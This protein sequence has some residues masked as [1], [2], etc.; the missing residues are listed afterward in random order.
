MK[1]NLLIEILCEELP[2]IPFL[3]EEKHILKKWE[4]ILDEYH[5]SAKFDFFYTP[6][7]LVLVSED[8]PE[9]QEDQE[10]EFFG[11][12][13]AIAYIDGDKTKG[14][15]KAGES[16]LKKCHAQSVE[17]IQKD[18][19]K[20]LY[21][22]QTLQGKSVQDLLGE[23]ILKWL[24]SLQFG[25]SMRWGNLESSFIRPIRSVVALF[26]QKP[27]EFELF[28]V[29][30]GSHTFIH[31]DYGFDPRSFESLDEYFKILQEGGVILD[32]QKRREKILQEMREIEIQ[33]DVEIELDEELLCEVVA[34]TESPRAVYG[35]FDREFLELPQEVII[36][37]MKENQRYFALYQNG[38]LHHGFIVVIN[39]MSDDTGLIIEGNQKV[40]RARLSD[41]MFF[42]HNDLKRPLASYDLSKVT[43][44]EGLG[45]M[46]DK[47]EREKAIAAFLSKNNAE[48]LEAVTISKSDLLSE[49]V[50]EFPELQGVMGEYYA[51][52]EANAG[53]ENRN[54]AIALALR[55]Q[56]MP[57]G[58]EDSLPTSEIG[59]F[60]ALSYRLDSLL[61]LFSVGK[62]PSGS[63]DPYGLRRSGNAVLK[64]LQAHC[65]ALSKDDIYQLAKNYQSF[66]VEK[67]WMFLTERM[68]G[69]LRINA[70]ILRSVINGRETDLKKMMQKALALFEVFE[71][72]EKESMLST[73]KRVANITKEIGGDPK[74]IDLSLFQETQEMELYQALQRIKA[75]PQS[76]LKGYIKALF[77]LK[78]PL[79]DFFDSVMVNAEDEKIRENRKNLIYAIYWMFLEIGDI[80]EITG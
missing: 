50:G 5:L 14:L 58:E 37:S 22:A 78:A 64:I 65:I 66:D 2:A 23:M 20:V 7:R 60:L 55:E 21:F 49:M 47:I 39:S 30:S 51:Q 18:G 74:E 15:S 40:L 69:V 32:P 43:F 56:Y 26:G 70:S 53:V 54:Q 41:A 31:R 24:E 10:V 52:A 38:K 16:F 8:F 46:A 75:Q 48:V 29:K 71:E 62:I 44:V 1:Q 73:F 72:E 63:K 4:M 9:R 28:G 3:K 67:L 17:E 6:R 57:N 25:K 42:Y 27:I 61:A 77:S 79:N 45:S 33:R 76:D 80:K 68:E 34:I 36:T 35:E 59:A 11:P 12:P 19:K 13:V